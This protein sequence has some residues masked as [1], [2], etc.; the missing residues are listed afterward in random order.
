M[1]KICFEQVIF[2]SDQFIQSLFYVY[3]GL[4]NN[5]VPKADQMNVRDNSFSLLTHYLHVMNLLEQP[6]GFN[7]YKM[8]SFFTIIF[9]IS[10]NFC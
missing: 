9:L 1:T 7:V 4:F 10:P 6:H 5:L 8:L 2:Y 3:E